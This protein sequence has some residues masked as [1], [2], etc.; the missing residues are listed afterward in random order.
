MSIHHFKFALLSL[1]IGG[2]F[3][4]SA[5][6]DDPG[7]NKDQQRNRQA[8]SKG[9]ESSD[10]LD[11]K[12]PESQAQTS[13]ADRTPDTHSNDTRSQDSKA[14]SRNS[15]K[16]QSSSDDHIHVPLRWVTVAVDY[17]Q[18]GRYDAWETIYYFDFQQASQ[19][20]RERSKQ[21][22][23]ELSSEAAEKTSIKGEIVQLKT[24]NSASGSET[25]VIAQVENSQGR[26]V[27]VC[28][29]PES[30]VS[31][32]N[33]SKGDHVSADGVVMRKDGQ[34]KLIAA[35]VEANGKT[36][37]H[38][39]TKRSMLNRVKGEL[40]SLSEAKSK[41]GDGIYLVG[42]IKTDS[43]KKTVHFGPKRQLSKLN[44]SEGDEV[45]AVTRT[46]TVNGNQAAIALQVSA[47]DETVKVVRQAK[48]GESGQSRDDQ[49]TQQNR[50]DG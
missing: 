4:L 24:D 28:L 35:K 19:R 49:E 46:G 47:N 34:L 11:D 30:K 42:T 7:R 29:G 3:S 18:D 20:S 15:K 16:S 1:T 50:N 33:L 6:A 32:L 2:L 31:K 12:D 37:T 14:N 36:V 8:Q 27:E 45:D 5:T 38:K 41:R 44:L 48:S 39:L 9:S 10:G 17:D 21:E 13:K 26:R 22:N 25:R 23:Q 40:T 43:G